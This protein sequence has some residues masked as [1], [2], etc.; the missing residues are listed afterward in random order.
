MFPV[1][2][3]DCKGDLVALALN[4]TD[5]HVHMANVLCESS[6]RPSDHDNP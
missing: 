1:S 3:P 5:V 6:S 2:L 4:Q